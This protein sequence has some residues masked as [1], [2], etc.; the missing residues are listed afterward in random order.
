MHVNIILLRRIE[1]I[2]GE[3]FQ[4]GI[5]ELA[6]KGQKDSYQTPFPNRNSIVYH[7]RICGQKK[8]NFLL[9]SWSG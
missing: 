5:L 9:H 2:T 7:V 4:S 8:T 6:D 1:S 3:N